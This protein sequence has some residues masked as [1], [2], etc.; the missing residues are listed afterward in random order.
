MAHQKRINKVVV[1]G[2]FGRFDYT[3]DF[4][5]NGRHES[6]ITI[7]TAPNGYGKSTLLKLID[8][9]VGARYAH[10]SRTIFSKLVVE[11][12]DGRSV[13]V[14]QK[15]KSKNEENEQT[16]LRF[17]SMRTKGPTKNDS[18]KVW[19]INFTPISE[20][21]IDDDFGT[22]APAYMHIERMVERELGLRRIGHR[23]W[24]D[25]N[26]GR[27]YNREQLITLYEDIQAGGGHYRKS[28]PEWLTNFRAVVTVLYI[29]AN[30]LR[31][32][33]RAGGPRRPRGAEMVEVVCDRVLDQIRRFN[34]KYSETGRRLEQDFPER[35]IHAIGSGEKIEQ[36]GILRLINKVRM[37]E[38]EY[39]ELGLLSEVLTRRVNLA[40][41]DPSAL[42]VL[43]IYLQDIEQKLESLKST[44]ERLRIFIETLNSMLLFKKLRITPDIGFQVIGNDEK[45]I[46]LR[47]LSSGEQHL[48]VLLG[49]VIF[50]SV[51]SGLVL[52]D[53]P[54]LSFHPEWQER[55]P[56]VLSKVV[57]LN[58]CTIVMA[59]HSPTLI[60]DR[61]DSVI[62]L[63]DQ[64][65]Q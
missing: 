39:Q 45:T 50:G 27:I 34:A 43:G 32:T 8:D 57:Q 12:S 53:E 36:E 30:R 23:E 4:I 15:I 14:E 63:A 65:K 2:L 31:H 6:G 29:P 28:E 5:K 58:G 38:S 9:L 13:L 25:P 46:P 20:P 44:A 48:I 18:Q 11:T 37:Q 42:L 26:D 35:V 60:Q 59:T 54:E 51:E 47:S 33:D 1:G 24:R 40:I 22:H 21:E 7:I 52:L 56:E 10:L 49:E 17:T 62:E 19:E 61:W 64:V 16:V 41:K 55:F 3:L